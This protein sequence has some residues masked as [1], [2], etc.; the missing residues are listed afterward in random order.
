MYTWFVH[1]PVIQSIIWLL[2]YYLQKLLV[3]VTKATNYRQRASC[4]PKGRGSN[5]DHMVQAEGQ[6]SSERRG[7]GPMT[8]T[9]GQAEGQ[10]SIREK[11]RGPN[12][13]NRLQAEGQMSTKEKG[14]GPN[15]DHIMQ[16]EDQ[17]STRVK[18]R[19]PNADHLVQGKGV[20]IIASTQ[21]TPGWSLLC[22]KYATHSHNMYEKYSTK[23]I[24]AKE[25]IAS[26]FLQLIYNISYP[27]VF[28][29]GTLVRYNRYNI[30]LN[31]VCG[32]HVT[33][34]RS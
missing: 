10:M 32:T 24:S 26:F 1:T 23:R 29:N 11:G 13:N 3:T 25:L 19:G 7:E 18:G 9:W 31:I 12:A 16:A 20:N 8:A 6:M 30:S 28:K 34:F 21:I 2:I 14:R 5:A 4:R 15:V 22:S 27:A 33:Q 17:T